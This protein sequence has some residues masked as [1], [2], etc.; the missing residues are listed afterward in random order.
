MKLVVA[1]WN[2]NASERTIEQLREHLDGQN[3][4]VW[5]SVEGMRLKCWISD[6]SNNLW[7]AVML[8]EESRFMEQTL[9]PN[10]ATELIGYPPTL[11][12]SFDVEKTVE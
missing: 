1:W 12:L 11:R 5:R 2:L 7:G 10:I 4:D 6:S 9:P 3:V 8:W